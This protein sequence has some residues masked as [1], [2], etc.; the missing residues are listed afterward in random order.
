MLSK[1]C[2]KCKIIN[3]DKKNHYSYQDSTV[4]EGTS[5]QKLFTGSPFANNG[6][7]KK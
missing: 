2:L 4:K 5:G 6:K 1:Y 3:I 7:T